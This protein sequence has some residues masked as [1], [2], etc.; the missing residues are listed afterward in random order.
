M[1]LVNNENKKNIYLVFFVACQD[2]IVSTQ[3]ANS[4]SEAAIQTVKEAFDSSGDSYPISTKIIVLDV[5][6]LN[7]VVDYSLFNFDTGPLAQDAG[8]YNEAKKI[9]KI[10]EDKDEQT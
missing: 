9:K 10:M 6:K 8:L 5:M 4:P 7:H 3:W 2:K 1:I